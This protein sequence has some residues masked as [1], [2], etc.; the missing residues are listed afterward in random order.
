MTTPPN[1]VVATLVVG[2]SR[3]PSSDHALTV[4]ADLAGRLHARLHVV[5][6][7]DYR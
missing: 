6:V 2:H 1:D 4:A 7:G 3:D 5:D